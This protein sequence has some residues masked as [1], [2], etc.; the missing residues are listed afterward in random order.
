[1]NGLSRHLMVCFVTGLI[2]V[3]PIG[4]TIVLIALA[5]SS[6][7]PLIPEKWYFPGMAL[8]T[9]VVLLYLLGLTLSTVVGRWF[10]NR[11]DNVMDR[12]PGLGMI[13]RT[14]KQILGFEAGEGGL[15]QSVVLV[16]NEA[17]G[18]S[19]IGLVTS[20]ER[21]AE[22]QQLVVFVPGSPNPSQGRLVRLPAARAVRTDW[23]VD[24]ALKYL[25]SLGKISNGKADLVLT[26]GSVI[27]EKKNRQGT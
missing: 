22:S 3:L 6:F 16:P 1:M 25:F 24:R 27:L 12:L 13:Y 7:R 14:L 26:E 4:G 21:D 9:V 2:A 23:S 19:Q 5:E 15:F 8:I 17:T 11:L 18:W 10:W 20:V